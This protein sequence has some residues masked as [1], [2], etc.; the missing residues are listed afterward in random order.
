MNTELNDY[1]DCDRELEELSPAT[2][3]EAEPARSLP[4]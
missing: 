1:M 4:G 3:A 2:R